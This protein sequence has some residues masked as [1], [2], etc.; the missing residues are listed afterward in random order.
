M[1]EDL[2]MIAGDLF[3]PDPG[4]QDHGPVVSVPDFGKRLI[5]GHQA[6]E[7]AVLGGR[8]R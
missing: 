7:T 2:G 6:Q 8:P 3:P 5:V 1:I 4:E